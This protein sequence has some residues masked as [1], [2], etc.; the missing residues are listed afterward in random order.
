MDH[1]AWPQYSLPFQLINNTVM[2]QWMEIFRDIMDRAVPSVR[3]AFVIAVGKPFFWFSWFVLKWSLKQV[4]F[5]FF[6]RV[7]S[8]NMSIECE[9]FCTDV[10]V[11]VRRHWKLMR[12]TGPSWHGGSARS[13]RC[14]S[15]P[16]CLK[17][18]FSPLSMS[19]MTFIR[20]THYSGWIFRYGSPG[21]VTKEYSDFANFFLMTYAVGILQV[22]MLNSSGCI[23]S[24]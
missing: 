11:C 9:Y 8:Y 22:N 5:L 13:G 18:E 24:L 19:R 16:G 21:N 14:A 23:F 3:H 7:Q 20:H 12:M 4:L 2:T 10:C 17:G 1:V 15:L 6:K